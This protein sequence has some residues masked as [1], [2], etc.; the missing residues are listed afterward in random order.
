MTTVITPFFNNNE[1]SMNY[2]KTSNT[3]LCNPAT[4]KAPGNP[5]ELQLP[6]S[7]PSS[8]GSGERK[9]PMVRHP[10]LLEE[11]NFDVVLLESGKC[12]MV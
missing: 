5:S 1:K 2:S 7:R 3:L 8:T 10:G 12:S 9:G 6:C 11:E 4:Q